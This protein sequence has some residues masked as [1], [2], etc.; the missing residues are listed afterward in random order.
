MKENCFEEIYST[1]CIIEKQQQQQ[2]FKIDNLSFYVR[3][4]E[5][6]EQMKFK[7]GRQKEID[8]RWILHL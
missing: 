1:G 2:R 8:S 5:K 6:E 3:K 7:V 4:L